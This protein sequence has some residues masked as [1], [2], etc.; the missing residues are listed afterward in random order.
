MKKKMIHWLVIASIVLGSLCSV[1]FAQE[2]P[3]SSTISVNDTLES[4]ESKSYS[5]RFR[6]DSIY[7]VDEFILYYVYCTDT[8]DLKWGGIFWTKKNYY[9]I[10][11]TIVTYDA[12][13]TVGNLIKVG[14]SFDMDL[15]PYYGVW[16]LCE[17]YSG[18]IQYDKLYKR[19][20]EYITI[21]RDSIWS[22]LMTS[23]KIKGKYFCP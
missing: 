19:N 3:Q 5:G 14:D 20:G 10:G 23:P 6:V 9:G 11:L 13:D 4:I 8:V 7:R 22:Q 17:H 18:E 16:R 1:C 15:I 21:P 12:P 2:N